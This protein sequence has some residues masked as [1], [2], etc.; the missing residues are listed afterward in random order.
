MFYKKNDLPTAE[1]ANRLW[2]ICEESY[3]HGSPWNYQQFENDLNE[4]KSYY[5][6]LEEEQQIIGF[7]GCNLVLDEAEITNVVIAKA[8]Q[9]HGC[10]RKLLQE[11]LIQLKQQDV[12]QVFLEVRCS[13]VVAQNL[14]KSEKFRFLGLR[15]S[16]YHNPCE[17]A[18]IMSAK[19]RNCE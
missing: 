15:K 11:L 1:L 16:Y 6:I 3:E 5:L 4:T 12:F 13:N 2:T 8:F 7:V 9:G 18:V 10:A 14:Y 17:D 19:V